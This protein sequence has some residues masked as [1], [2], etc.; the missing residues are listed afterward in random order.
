M[1]IEAKKG[2][3]FLNIVFYQHGA[4]ILVVNNKII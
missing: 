4:M 1:A 3:R 2:G